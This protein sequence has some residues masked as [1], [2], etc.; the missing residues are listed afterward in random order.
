[1][2]LA[3]FTEY[4][5][6][7][8]IEGVHDEGVREYER[9]SDELVRERNRRRASRGL[10]PMT[11]VEETRLIKAEVQDP[12][13]YA[14][15]APTGRGLETMYTG[16]IRKDRKPRFGEDMVKRTVTF[17]GNVN[18]LGAEAKRMLWFNSTLF[19]A[20]TRSRFKTVGALVDFLLFLD[21]GCSRDESIL[22]ADEVD[23]RGDPPLN[24]CMNGMDYVQVSEVF[25]ACLW[26]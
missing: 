9:M 15:P 13:N 12:W 14:W 4:Q 18:A 3:R 25:F 22:R 16:V 23:R 2:C 11:P 7:A 26:G 24:M 1:M 19:A 5:I 10:P 17:N 8:L 20:T 6:A 21:R